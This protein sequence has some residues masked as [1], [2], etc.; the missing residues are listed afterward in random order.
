MKSNIPKNFNSTK[1]CVNQSRFLS[2][3]HGVKSVDDV[4]KIIK[5]YRVKYYDATHV[6]YGYCILI[7]NDLSYSGSD[8]NEPKNSAVIPILKA[9]KQFDMV[10]TLIIVI[11]YFGTSLLGK[12]LLSKTYYDV[13]FKVLES[14]EKQQV[15]R[16]Y[17]YEISF[18]INDTKLYQKMINQI[19]EFTI[20]KKEYKSDC[21][22]IELRSKDQ[23]NFDNDKITIR[24][25]DYG[26]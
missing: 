9:I 13:S 19:N 16:M 14:L 7:K 2:F 5:E 6:C 26:Y 24:L 25:K 12:K 21:V 11:R 8:D 18:K 1:I 17:H 3:V 10:N 20:I 23:I 22:R 15:T 4:K